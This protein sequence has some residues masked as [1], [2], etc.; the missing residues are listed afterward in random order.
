MVQNNSSPP[1]EAY[2]LYSIIIELGAAR[3]GNPPATLG[4]AIH[5]QVLHWIQLGDPQLAETI[6]TSQNPPISLSG[7]QGNRRKEKN[8][9]GDRFYFR[10]CFLQGHLIQPLL[11]GIEAWGEE[12]LILG[13]FPF[14]IR[15]CYFLSGTHSLARSTDYENL[16]N[17]SPVSQTISLSFLSPTSFKQQKHIQ[18]LL[19]PDLVFN[20]LLRKWNSFAPEELH[21]PLIEWDGFVSAF[22]LRSYALKMEGGAEVGSQGWVKYCFSDSEQARIASILAQFAFYSGV[23]RKTTM[24]MGQVQLLL[25]NN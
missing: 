8:Y 19:T 23:G 5:A 6:H 21:F 17:H 14:V 7:L 25:R 4:R 20:S 22:D 9:A 10:I 11:K 12:K 3:S 2:K 15:Q 1:K 16:V 24:G 13:Q 18:L